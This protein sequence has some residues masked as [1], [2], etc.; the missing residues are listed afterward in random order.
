MPTSPG[1]SRKYPDDVP[2]PRKFALVI[3]CVDYRLLDDLVRFLCHENLTNR[4]YHIAFA[5]AALCLSEEIDRWPVPKCGRPDGAPWRATLRDHLGAVVALTGGKLSDVYIVEHRDC[6][7]FEKFL[8][9]QYYP[10]DGPPRL[11]DESADHA[12]FAHALRRELAA[13]FAAHAASASASG[14]SDCPTVTQHPPHIHCFLMGLR[15][16]IERLDEPKPK[17]RA[18]K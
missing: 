11:D 5:G 4:Y 14:T 13:W 18:K 8:G 12:T 1:L 16:E 17:K 15:G 6:G 2:P 10:D 9:E 3:S 7:A